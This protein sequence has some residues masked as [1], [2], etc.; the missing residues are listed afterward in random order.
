MK[1]KKDLSKLP[2]HFYNSVSAG[3]FPCMD[4]E[5]ECSLCSRGKKRATPVLKRPRI[6]CSY[7]GRTMHPDMVC[8]YY[9]KSLA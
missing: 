5:G 4:T 6:W 7:V 8:P 3:T 9:E 2:K 1:P